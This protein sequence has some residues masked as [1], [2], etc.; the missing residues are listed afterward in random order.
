MPSAVTCM[1]CTAV[2]PC[3][4]Y[5]LQ[6][7]A[8]AMQPA[9]A[10]AQQTARLLAE[11]CA[12]MRQRRG[13]ALLGCPHL[14]ARL[15]A[16]E[17]YLGRL[18]RSAEHAYM[19]RTNTCLH[20]GSYTSHM[21]S[22]LKCITRAAEYFQFVTYSSL[23]QQATSVTGQVPHMH[24]KLR[25]CLSSSARSSASAATNCSSAAASSA[26]ASARAWST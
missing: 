1:A 20:G 15:V 6:D 8:R 13:E 3:R 17:Q 14:S 7:Q 25:A 9:A 22:A 23:R 4:T 26:R 2:P 21:P 24:S 10:H 19:C 18:P 5:S 11:L 16:S 12:L